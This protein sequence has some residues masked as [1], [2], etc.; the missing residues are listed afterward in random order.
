MATPVRP[1]L[2]NTP[3]TSYLAENTFEKEAKSE[4]KRNSAIS[5]A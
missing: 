3:G 1:G 4:T 2:L 5:L